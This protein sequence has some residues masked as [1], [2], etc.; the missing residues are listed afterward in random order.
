MDTQARDLGPRTLLLAA[1]V[2]AAAPCA[3]ADGPPAAQKAPAAAAPAAS[4]HPTQPLDLRAPPV[5]HVMP[6]SQVQTL[7]TDN[8]PAQGED[9]RVEQTRYHEQPPVG[10]FQALPWG[11]THPMQAWR[12]FTPVVTP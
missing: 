12:L 11:L 1:I 9:V 5:E 8:S 10:F 7:V 4:P 6:H 3:W 2:A